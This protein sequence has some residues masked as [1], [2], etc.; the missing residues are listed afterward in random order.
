MAAA[1]HVLYTAKGRSMRTLVLHTCM[2]RSCCWLHRILTRKKFKSDPIC[3]K[4]IDM[5]STSA[6]PV[7]EVNSTKHRMVFDKTKK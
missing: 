5:H 1:V 6:S 2:Y 4:F 3:D 7:V